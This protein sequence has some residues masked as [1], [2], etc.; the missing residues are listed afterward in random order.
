[1]RYIFILSYLCSISIVSC[2][3][4]KN[5]IIYS[6]HDASIKRIDYNSKTKFHYFYKGKE[7]G[8][9]WVEYSGI[10]DGFSGYLKFE[11]NGTVTLLSGDGYFQSNGNAT[12]FN[13]K[14]ILSNE[15]P[16]LG[17][18][19]VYQIQ[20]STRYEKE[21]NQNTKSKVEVKYN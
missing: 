3:N 1:M 19:G 5:V 11:L 12:G 14:R 8:I 7:N 21:N 20:L 2:G 15:N 9:I 18:E 17:E 16:V 6:Y 4:K 13:Y 10:N